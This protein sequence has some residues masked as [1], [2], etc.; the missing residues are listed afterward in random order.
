TMVNT[1]ADGFPLEVSETVVVAEHPASQTIAPGGNAAL[2]VQA[3]GTGALR[4]QWR[5]NGVAIVGATNASLPIANVTAANAGDYEAIVTDVNGP[6]V[7]RMARL[8]V[9][10]PNPGRLVNLSVRGSARSAA[11]PLIVGFSVT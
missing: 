8:A 7:S 4:Y 10:T 3:T 9:E 2:S 5:R 6:I 1:P 11:A